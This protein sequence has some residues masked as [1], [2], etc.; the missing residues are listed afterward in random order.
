MGIADLLSDGIVGGAEFDAAVEAA[1]ATDIAA[2]VALTHHADADVRL[3]AIQTLP[4]TTHGGRP[5][6]EMVA[7]ALALTVDSDPRIRDWACFALGQIWDDIDTEAVRDALAD[8]LDDTDTDTRCEA[9]LGLALRRDPRALPALQAALSRPDGDLFRLELQA[10]GALADPRLHPL[11]LNHQTGWDDD[12][13]DAPMAHL[14]RR[15]TD[16]AGVGADV[17]DGVA[18]LN[19]HRAHGQPDGNSLSA[20]TLMSKM[21]DIAPWRA[22]DLLHAVRAQLAGDDAAVRQLEEN[23][24]LAS[25]VTSSQ[26]ST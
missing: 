25:L 6:P 19:R 26:E 7:A 17:I 9:L 15:L 8:R 10:A 1:D 22:E 23:S 12:D 21:L 4:G 3:A 18:E 16:P 20:W 2:V 24:A 11:V 5:S 14:V 13:T